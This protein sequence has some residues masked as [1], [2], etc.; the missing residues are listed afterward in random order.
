MKDFVKNQINRQRLL[1]IYLRRSVSW[2][3]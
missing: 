1:R 3:N 2:E